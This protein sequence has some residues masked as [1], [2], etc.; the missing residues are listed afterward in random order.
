MTTEML[1]ITSEDMLA[2]PDQ[3]E[4]DRWIIQG[5]L[6]ERS[7]T[8]RR[9]SHAA[10]TAALTFYLQQW[11]VK[12][13][14]PRPKVYNGDIYFRLAVDPDTNV[15]ID[16][17]LSTPEQAAATGL[18]SR[19]IEGAPLLAVE[20]LSASDTAEDIQEKI[21]AYLTAGT[22]LVWIVNPFNATVLVYRPHEEPVLFNRNQ[23]LIG[24]PILEGF[25]IPV[26]EIFA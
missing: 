1:A 25:R 18:S 20:V 24:D 7:M 3:D 16:I 6:R 5:E 12:R 8:R 22:P 19:F 14:R 15:G 2:L 21:E 13:P 23:E 4:F 11:V 9:P 26:A 17:A 10:A